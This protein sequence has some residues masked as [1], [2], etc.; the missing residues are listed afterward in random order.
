MYAVC[1][2]E[3]CD[4][5]VNSRGWCHKHYY[6]WYV[7]GDPTF[8]CQSRKLKYKN[9]RDVLESGFLKREPDD[10]WEWLRSLSPFGY[11]KAWWN[12]K[13]YQAHRLSWE[14]YNGEIPDGLCVLHRC[15]NPKCIN[16]S[17]LFLGSHKDNNKDMAKKGRHWDCRGSNNPRTNLTEENI[18]E[19]RSLIQ[20]GVSPLEISTMYNV[21]RPVIYEI[22]SGKNWS[23]VKE[24]DRGREKKEI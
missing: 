12:G 7:H 10:C 21:N 9:S 4:R 22:K 19:I 2:I 5:E 6:R 11:G 3:G 16:P 17:H 24:N 8:T 20:K 13:M 1:S 15:D 18:L 23:H 14:A